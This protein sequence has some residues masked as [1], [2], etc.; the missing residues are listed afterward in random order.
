MEKQDVSFDFW[1]ADIEGEIADFVG[2]S[3]AFSEIRYDIDNG[4][5]KGKIFDYQDFALECYELKKPI[6]NY[7]TWLKF[8][9]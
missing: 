5:E 9:L 2:Y 1:I 7:R 4:I 3:I 8:K 6:I